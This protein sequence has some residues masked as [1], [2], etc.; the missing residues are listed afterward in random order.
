MRLNA[1]AKINLTL[2]ITGVRPNGFHTLRSVMAPITLCDELTFE[3]SDEFVFDCN[4]EALKSED[5]LCV[6]AAK[7][8]FDKIGVKPQGSIFL[9][10]KIPFPAG[11]GGGSSDAA[12]VLKGLNELYGS[13]LDKSELLSLAEKLGSV[14]EQ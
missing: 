4:I 11:L 14:V 8:F 13:L 12:T 9:E 1:N 2:D 6:R 7:L 10:K 3:K 5:N